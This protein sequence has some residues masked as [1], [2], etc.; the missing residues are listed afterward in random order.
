MAAALGAAAAVLSAG[1]DKT[2]TNLLNACLRAVQNSHSCTSRWL[3]TIPTQRTLAITGGRAKRGLPSSP[4]PAARRAVFKREEEAPHSSWLEAAVALWRMARACVGQ[5]GKGRTSFL[6]LL[7]AHLFGG[8][9]HGLLLLGLLLAEGNVLLRGRQTARRTQNTPVGETPA[10][11]AAAK[12]T[13]LPTH[14]PRSKGFLDGARPVARW[15]RAGCTET[16]LA[17]AAESSASLS[18]SSRCVAHRRRRRDGVCEQMGG[19]DYG[20]TSSMDFPFAFF[21]LAVFAVLLPP[22]RPGIL[23]GSAVYRQVVSI[24]RWPPRRPRTTVATRHYM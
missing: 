19:R 20:R 23:S 2:R 18:L 16:S 15:S 8:G 6:L 11:R 13:P 7:A 14:P 24:G 10:L 5:C 1:A 9:L 22:A 4:S 12:C 17:G 3:S 21:C